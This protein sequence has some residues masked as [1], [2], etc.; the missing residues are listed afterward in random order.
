MAIVVAGV[1]LTIFMFLAA[2]VGVFVTIYAIAVPEQVGIVFS[3]IAWI[4]GI[5]SLILFIV[6]IVKH[7]HRDDIIMILSVGYFIVGILGFVALYFMKHG[8]TLTQTAAQAV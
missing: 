1:A 5:S 7:A 2:V 3:V 4:W 8:F 6:A